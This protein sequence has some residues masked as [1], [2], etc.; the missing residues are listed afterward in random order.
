M[1]HLMP[2]SLLGTLCTSWTWV[3]VFS[4]VLGKFFA[5]ISSNI[6]SDP[7]SLSSPSGTPMMQMLV[8]FMVSQRL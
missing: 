5:T 1:K 4:P 3:A 7:F 8:H 2:F 6:F